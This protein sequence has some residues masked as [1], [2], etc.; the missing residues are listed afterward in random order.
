MIE[1]V[2]SDWYF[3]TVELGI[4]ALNKKRE[5]YTQQSSKPGITTQK[6]LKKRFAPDKKDYKYI[7][8]NPKAFKYI[9]YI[10]EWQAIKLERLIQRNI[11]RYFPQNN[12][13]DY[14]YAFHNFYSP[15]KAKGITEVR[16]YNADEIKY[17][18]NFISTVDFD[19]KIEKL[20]RGENILENPQHGVIT[21]YFNEIIK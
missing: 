16:I 3:Y 14:P 9:G 4:E 6:N 10:Y 7:D 1:E 21:G 2:K 13:P 20:V 5:L 15:K 18:N 11:I 19:K 12:H 8:Y 17:I